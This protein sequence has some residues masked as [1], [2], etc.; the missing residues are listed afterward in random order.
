MEVIVK[1]TDPHMKMRRLPYTSAS[2]P[3][4]SYIDV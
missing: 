1:A 2:R 4:K 3:H